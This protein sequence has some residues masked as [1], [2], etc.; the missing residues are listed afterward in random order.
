MI[1]GSAL[2]NFKTVGDRVLENRFAP[3]S[4]GSYQIVHYYC[5][6]L[7]ICSLLKRYAAFHR[8]VEADLLID[9]ERGKT[10]NQVWS[11]VLLSPFGSKNS[12]PGPIFSFH[13]RAG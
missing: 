11:L 6:F 13:L 4:S 7:S 1:A 10:L 5:L 2:S 3:A 8:A 9:A 12:R